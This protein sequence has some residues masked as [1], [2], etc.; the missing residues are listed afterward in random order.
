MSKQLSRLYGDCEIQALVDPRFAIE[1]VDDQ[2]GI[3]MD[4][5]S[6]WRSRT[7]VFQDMQDTGIFGQVAGHCLTLANHA[8]VPQENGAVFTFDD[9]SEAGSSSRIDRFAGSIESG[10]ELWFF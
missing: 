6:P 5:H 9:D 7:Q 10:K 8:M 3:T 1:L 4:R 2:V